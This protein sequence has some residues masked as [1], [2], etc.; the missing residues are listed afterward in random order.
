MKIQR[1]TKRTA[2]SCPRARKLHERVHGPDKGP[3]RGEGGGPAAG[4]RHSALDD[5]TPRAG[6]ALL[7]GRL[8]RRAQARAHS[9]RH[10][11]LH[12]RDLLRP[13]RHRLGRQRLRQAQPGLSRLL[14]GPA[15]A[16]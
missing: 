10:P 16:L 6:R 14:D 11:G 5:D 2:S 1:M 12:V 3:L 8:E 15:E 13:G 9:R 7:R 4:R